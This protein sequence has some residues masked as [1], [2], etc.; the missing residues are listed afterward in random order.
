[1]YVLIKR[2]VILST[3]LGYEE[4]TN[5]LSKIINGNFYKYR[6][7]A[8]S[9]QKESDTFKMHKI[10]FD[11]SNAF[12]PSLTVKINKQNGVNY[13]HLIFTFQKK[14]I[15]LI[16]FLAIFN[17]GWIVSSAKKDMMWNGIS[18]V[19]II[20]VISCF[21]ATYM[22]NSSCARI[23]EDFLKL[24][25]AELVKNFDITEEYKKL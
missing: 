16:I 24:F 3:K 22:F 14:V 19:L 9:D 8:F 25:K 21:V 13:M 7:G 20:D 10:A 6:V 23:E 17:I 5:I 11:Q 12:M 18:T 15:V 2:E 1:M 4:I